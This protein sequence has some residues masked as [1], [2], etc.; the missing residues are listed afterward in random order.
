MKQANTSLPPDCRPRIL[1][2]RQ[3]RTK[4]C[5]PGGTRKGLFLLKNVKTIK[6]N[7]GGGA[8]FSVVVGLNR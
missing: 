2:L 6:K 1:L 3:R 8:V 7:A 5:R 4:I